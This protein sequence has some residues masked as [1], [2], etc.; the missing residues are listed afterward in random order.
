MTFKSS[1]RILLPLALAWIPLGHGTAVAVA[2]GPPAERE[3]QARIWMDRG[4][5]PVLDR[6]DRVR[7]YFRSSRDAYTALFHIDTSGTVRLLFP[8]APGEAEWIRG[9]QDYRLLFPA[10]TAWVVNEDPGVGYF[11]LLTSLEPLDYSRFAYSP[12]TGGWDLSR[13]GSRVY[14][15]PY[16]AM[17]E[18]VEV[19]LPEWEYAEFSL[20]Y[21]SY[22]VG[23][24]YSYP[25]FLCY[26]CHTYQRFQ[27]WNPYHRACSTFRVVIY[28]DPYY[29]PST[30]YRGT[31]VVHT[32]P[33]LS[34][35][36]QFT[37]KERASGEPGTPLVRAGPG[38]REGGTLP[39]ELTRGDRIGEAMPR[40]GGERPV[41]RPGVQ[42]REPPIGE[43]LPTV[44]RD[45]T[46]SRGQVMDADPR[47]TT[48]QGPRPGSDVRPERG[49]PTVRPPVSTDRRPVLE[50]RVPPRSRDGGDRPSSRG[51][52][53]PGADRGASVGRD[54]DP[55]GGVRPRSPGAV[56]PP[57]RGGNPPVRGGTPPVRSGN[58]S[59]RPGSPP[60][61]GPQRR[62]PP[63]AERRPPARRAG[64]GGG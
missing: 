49:E 36:P 8:G 32:R 31:R 21:A 22:N 55:P 7:V 51:I 54:P 27:S 41:L 14:R 44:I 4:P 28:N 33:A 58:P 43:P 24:S 25:R 12:L 59:V 38:S 3:L 45:R 26:D 19:L 57:V 29:Y 48:M 40:A 5:D 2:P 1:Y 56:R 35:L 13:V 9:G 15:D 18:F 16:V 52:D 20:D 6:G 61:T 34:R 47:G 39:S 10:S 50:R 60:R 53:R 30:R 11:F 23:Q 17:D 62:P 63:G 42:D 37:F 46:G 64:G